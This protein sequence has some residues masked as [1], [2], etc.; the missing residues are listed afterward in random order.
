MWS[1]AC[2]CVLECIYAVSMN[3]KCMGKRKRLVQ[4]LCFFLLSVFLRKCVALYRLSDILGVH[5]AFVGIKIVCAKQT[6]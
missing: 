5:W 4:V 2:L 6:S 3:S 1:L